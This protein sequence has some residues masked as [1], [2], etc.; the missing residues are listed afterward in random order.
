MVFHN[1]A[2]QAM[3]LAGNL[4]LDELLEMGVELTI[5]EKVDPMHELWM[6]DE[7]KVKHGDKHRSHVH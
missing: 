7:L 1:K 4:T 3:K 6:A 2:G 5:S